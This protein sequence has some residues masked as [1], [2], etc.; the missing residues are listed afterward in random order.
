MY[1]D[2]VTQLS[3]KIETQ[4]QTIM[5]GI[6]AIQG[7]N[8][9]SNSE[10]IN[11]LSNYLVRKRSRLALY[12]FFIEAGI[13]DEP[14]IKEFVRLE[15]MGV[16]AAI[17]GKK[18]VILFRKPQIR[19]NAEGQISS[20]KEAAIKTRTKEY[21]FI[22]GVY[23][24]EPK[25][26]TG[27][28]THTLPSIDIINMQNSEWKSIAIKVIGYEKILKSMKSAI[29]VI[30][31]Y[32]MKNY[33]DEDITYE[34]LELSLEDDRFVL[35]VDGK[36]LTDEDRDSGRRL[37]MQ[38]DADVVT[39]ARFVKVQDHTTRKETILRVPPNMNDCWSAIAWTFGKDKG[40]YAPK[41]ER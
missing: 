18:E 1:G 36:P 11:T 29:K 7:G 21:Y 39:T 4:M 35:S 12:S 10:Y 25:I 22:D 28:I 15:D 37:F 40:T 33:K 23:I 2:I 9:W 19:L 30:D 16:F 5:N 31:T 8:R 3:A 20:L 26:W 6:I 13:I 38:R 41:A 14:K 32:K 34:L 24:N 27:I 17:F